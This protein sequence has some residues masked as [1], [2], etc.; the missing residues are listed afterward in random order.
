MKALDNPEQYGL[1]D[2]L[3]RKL[4]GNGDMT[5]QLFGESLLE[6]GRELSHRLGYNE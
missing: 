1:D 4:L 5:Y 2:P 3:R 6:A